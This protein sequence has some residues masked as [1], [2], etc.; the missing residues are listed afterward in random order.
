MYG[1]NMM[2]QGGYINPA[3]VPSGA[4]VN[5]AMMYYPSAS[6]EGA[7]LEQSQ[8]KYDSAD[9]PGQLAGDS[10]SS[11]NKRSQNT[12]QSGQANYDEYAYNSMMMNQYYYPN[13]YPADSQQQV[14]GQYDHNPRDDRSVNDRNFDRRDRRRNGHDE[15]ERRPRGGSDNRHARGYHPY[16]R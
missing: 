1:G 11:P 13:Y 3:M 8:N 12:G 10:E 9:E 7:S 14:H 15:Y 2:M 16:T 5:P 4:Y 6:S